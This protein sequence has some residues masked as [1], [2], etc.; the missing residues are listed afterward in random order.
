M[1]DEDA[2]DELRALFANEKPKSKRP[3]GK[4]KHEAAP[5]LPAPV[6]DVARRY[7]QA[8]ELRAENQRRHTAWSKRA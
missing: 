2:W 1:T 6:L 5:A 3:A 4:T 7:T 8:A